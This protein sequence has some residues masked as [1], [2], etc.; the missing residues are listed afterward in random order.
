MSIGTVAAR[1]SATSSQPRLRVLVVDDSAVV[2]RAISDMLAT[3]SDIEVVGSV[4]SGKL[5]LSAVTQSAPDIVTLD[6]EMPDMD[7]LQ[8]LVALK[9]LAPKLVVL[10]C[11]AQTQRCAAVTLDALSRGAADYVAKPSNAADLARLKVDL[12]TKI[13][14]LGRRP[15]RVAPVPLGGPA[16]GPQTAGGRAGR[17]EP[18]GRVDLIAIGCST[19]G[20]EALTMLL[21]SL[22]GPL[23]VPV[24]IVQHMPPTFTRLLAERLDGK[25]GMRVREAAP[26]VNPVPGFVY[27]APGDAHLVVRNA[28]AA[29]QL[30]L[31]QDPPENGSRPAVDVLFR[32]VAKVAR[33]RV[34]AVVLTGM[35]QDGARGAEAV[36]AAGGTVW[37]QDEATS[38]VWGMPGSVSRGGFMHRTLPLN[39]IGPALSRRSA[40][41]RE[42]GIAKRS[43]R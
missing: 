25:S 29:M 26:G 36:V 32:S 7:G 15:S 30:A 5:A 21:G 20:P 17:E 39:E 22:G 41:G 13:R 31:T 28:G 24:V 18:K 10:M 3:E 42:G 35:G 12:V 1:A 23:P 16:L 8:T 40:Q 33:D 43:P 37:I 14:A 4:A 34:V 11:S 9:K 19:G 2:R 6:V 27:I 38:A